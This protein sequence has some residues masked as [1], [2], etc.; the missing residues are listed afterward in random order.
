MAVPVIEAPDGRRALP[1]FTSSAALARWR[2]DARPV[3]VPLH[4][5]LQAV[6]HERADTLLID[7]AGPVPYEL[8]GADLRAAARGG[9][10]RDPLADPAVREAVAVALRTALAAQPGVVR[11]HLGPA[12]PGNDGTLAL[13]LADDADPAAT[14]QAVA[15]ALAAD[16]TLRAVLVQGLDLAL[17]PAAAV[18]P[19]APLFSR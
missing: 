19:G 12:R 8:T 4:Q 16:E 7:L 15:R 5:A 9:A 3:A 17:L 10:G 14:G 13:V 1:A 2:A 11:A 18:L 6:A